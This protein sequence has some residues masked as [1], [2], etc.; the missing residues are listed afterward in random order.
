MFPACISFEVDETV[1]LLRES[2]PVACVPHECGECGDTIHPGERYEKH[3]T[4]SEGE[5]AVYKTCILCQRIRDSLFTHNW[6]YGRIWEEIHEMCCG[7]DE[8]TD[9][10]FCI[11]P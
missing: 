6:Y 10:D 3:V 8:D 7:Y 4:V 2:F 5:M 11:C 9:E 1:T